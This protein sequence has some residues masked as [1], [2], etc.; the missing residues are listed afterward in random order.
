LTR[1]ITGSEFTPPASVPDGT[2][3]RIDAS[4]SMVSMNQNLK[5]GFG[6]QFSG[7]S[8]A[9]N[10]NGSDKGIQGFIVGTVDIAPGKFGL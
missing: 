1:E 2:V 6:G 7:T 8:V 10:A 4:T 9:A 5:R 3:V